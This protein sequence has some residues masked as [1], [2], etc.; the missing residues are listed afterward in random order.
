MTT[1]PHG[2]EPYCEATN[3]YARNDIFLTI[4]PEARN[5]KLEAHVGMIYLIAGPFPWPC[6]PDQFAKW[7]GDLLMVKVAGEGML[8]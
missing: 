3:T 1:I 6:T 8:L 7:E 5:A 4:Y 2:Y